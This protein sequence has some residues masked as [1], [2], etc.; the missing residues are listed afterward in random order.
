MV[1]CKISE[2]KNLCMCL[3]KPHFKKKKIWIEKSIVRE[4]D[5]TPYV[6]MT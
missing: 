5:S 6:G 4:C 3:K 2:V 1:M